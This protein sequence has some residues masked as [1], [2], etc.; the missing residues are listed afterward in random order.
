M[1]QTIR[2]AW[3]Y[4]MWGFWRR[5]EERHRNAKTHHTNQYRHAASQAFKYKLLYTARG[6][7]DLYKG[8]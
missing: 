6:K 3:I 1:L 7:S 2:Y 4:L 5:K 8:L